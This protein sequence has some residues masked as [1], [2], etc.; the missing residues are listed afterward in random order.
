M[1]DMQASE[2]QALNQANK[3]RHETANAGIR[4]MS[5]AP[6]GGQPPISATLRLQTTAVPNPPQT[7]E[8]SAALVRDAQ[9]ALEASPAMQLGP[10]AKPPPLPALQGLC[11]L[12]YVQRQVEGLY[13]VLM[14][15]PAH[16]LHC[17]WYYLVNLLACVM[18]CEV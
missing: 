10:P 8:E 2:M 14:P 17:I 15:N 18:L 7:A 1:A 4:Q 16:N 9:L 11:S 3:L 6:G 13:S 12:Y 5:A